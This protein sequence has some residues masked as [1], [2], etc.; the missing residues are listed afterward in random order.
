MASSLDQLYALNIPA[1]RELFIQAMQQ[2]ADD[3]QIQEMIKA[4]ENND[5]EALYRASGFTPVVLNSLIDKIEEVYEKAANLTIDGWPKR[6]RTPLGL[7]KPVFNIRNEKVEEDLK[8]FSSNFVKNID[9]EVRENLRFALSEGMERGD[10]PRQTALNIVGRVNTSTKKREGGIIGLSTNQARWSASARRY[11]EN[12]DDK[13]FNLELRDKRFDSLVKKAIAEG[14]KL[15]KE[16]VTRLVTAYE[17]KA[18][19]YRGDAI[20]RTETIQ[21]IN[22]AERVAIAQ[23][24]EEGLIKEEQVRKWWDDSGDSRTRLSHLALGNKYNKNNTIGFNE[25][26]E[27]ST[28]SR[29][30]YPGDSSLGA[31][32]REIVHC[33]CVARYKIDFLKE[34]L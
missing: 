3:A 28:G 23:N 8:N 24:I 33:R 19:K 16:D 31:N 18:L 25:P 2:V 6:I 5:L 12:L 11:L 30:L 17:R 14:K 7:A 4:I 22:R 34:Y 29:L 15:T 10:N 26:F 13:Y 27:T 21:S 20:A 9:N 1:V 32:P